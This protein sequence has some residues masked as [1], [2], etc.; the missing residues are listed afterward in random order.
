MNIYR[1]ITELPAFKN[2]VLTIGS[3]DGVH[4]GHQQII[5]QLVETA[6]S[7]KCESVVVTFHPHPRHVVQTTD[8]NQLSASL[9]LLNTLEEKAELLQK[10]GVDNLVVVP[11]DETF[12]NQTAET[13][14]SDFLIKC[15]APSLIIIGYDHR[16]GKNRS[17]GLEQLKQA[18]NLYNYELLEISP[19][20]VADMRVSSSK[21]R[22]ALL[23]AAPAQAAQLLGY[24]YT[25]KGKVIHGKQIGRSLGFP[26]ANIHPTDPE[27]LIP[28]VGIYA[29]RVWVENELCGGMLYIGHRPSL[30]AALEQSIEVNIFGF[31][32]LIYDQFIRIEMVDF[33]RA[34]AT[35]PTFEALKTQLQ[36]DKIAALAILSQK[37]TPV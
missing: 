37:N 3:F 26:T 21:I 14:I 18:A 29:V 9:Q 27:K 31:D 34:D 8:P 13:Y 10:L 17:G 23:S 5:H 19:H 32:K 24:P 4:L 7:R 22:L 16:F 35:Y 28:S 20:D 36:A 15:F 11:F 6:R 33:V 12:A 30:G 1:Q 25:L 2:T